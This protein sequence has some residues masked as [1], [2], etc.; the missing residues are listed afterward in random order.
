LQ[1]DAFVTFGIYSRTA[2]TGAYCEIGNYGN[3]V[4]NGHGLLIYSKY[5]D[6]LAYF[7]N[8]PLLSTSS[9]NSQGLFAALRNQ[10]AAFSTYRNGVLLAVNN[11]QANVG[12]DPPQPIAILARPAAD[13]DAAPALFSSRNL[14]FAFLTN[15]IGTPGIGNIASVAKMADLYSVVQYFQTKIGR[16]V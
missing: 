16:Q 14:A 15:K 13:P 10:P 5:T 3:Y 4:A 12:I 8:G 11:T 1:A 9:V 2:S 6:G 7:A